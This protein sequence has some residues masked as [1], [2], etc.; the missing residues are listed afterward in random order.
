MVFIGKIGIHMSYLMFY[1]EYKANKCSYFTSKKWQEGVANFRNGAIISALVRPAVVKNSIGWLK[2]GDTDEV[3]FPQ[4]KIGRRKGKY[5][6]EM[7][8]RGKR[9]VIFFGEL[10]ED[11]FVCVSAV[12]N[13]R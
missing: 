2:G 3:T 1:F 7:V 4:E 8:R 5:R 6:W 10:L 11:G 13:R 9:E 12:K